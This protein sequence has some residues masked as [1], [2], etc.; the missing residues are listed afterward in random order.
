MCAISCEINI[1]ILHLPLPCLASTSYFRKTFTSKSQEVHH[2]SQWTSA[3][4]HRAGVE[5]MMGGIDSVESGA[6]IVNRTRIYSGCPGSHRG[7]SK[8]INPTPIRSSRRALLATA[9]LCSS[10]FH[11]HQFGTTESSIEAPLRALRS[12]CHRS[13]CH[14]E[15]PRT[16][17]CSS[18][19]TQMQQSQAPR[20]LQEHR[21]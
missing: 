4:A 5:G 2:Q 8:N 7:I 11:V 16:G 6:D 18:C 13:R 21:Q 15:R 12:C 19:G 10:C 1:F 14:P 20:R 9:C 17:S 3:L